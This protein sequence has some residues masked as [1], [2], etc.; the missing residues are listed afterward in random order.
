M[1]QD[2]PGQGSALDAGEHVAAL[3]GHLLQQQRKDYKQLCG[4]RGMHK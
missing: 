3:L 4:S 2:S 1:L